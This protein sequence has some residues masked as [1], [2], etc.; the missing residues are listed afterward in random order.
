MM[1]SRFGKLVE[2]AACGDAE[3]A[4]E[5]KRVL[6]SYEGKTQAEMIKLAIEYEKPRD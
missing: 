6:K 1:K 3:A 5:I 2:A 4:E